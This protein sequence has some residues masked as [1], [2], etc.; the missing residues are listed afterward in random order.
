MSLSA[1][2][3]TVDFPSDRRKPTRI[4]AAEKLPGAVEPPTL[5]KIEAG[6]REDARAM[7]KAPE[8]AHLV[9]ALLEDARRRQEI[10]A[11]AG[12]AARIDQAEALLRQLRG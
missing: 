11:N 6:T 3:W 12:T 4:L 7:A 8:L 5:A 10:E 2:P 1:Y 9:A